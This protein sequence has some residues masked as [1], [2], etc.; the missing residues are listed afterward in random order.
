MDPLVKA[1]ENKMEQNSDYV[2][3][4]VKKSTAPIRNKN[5]LMARQLMKMPQYYSVSSDPHLQKYLRRKEKIS[6]GQK[7]K[8]AR[9]DY[10]SYIDW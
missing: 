1:F 8:L 4:R 2:I 5:N 9:K 6:G 10:F 7:H 3:K